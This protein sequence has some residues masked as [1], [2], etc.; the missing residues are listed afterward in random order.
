MA[1]KEGGRFGGGSEM[2]SRSG[3]SAL[4]NCRRTSV[5]ASKPVPYSG[6]TRRDG[7]TLFRQRN[8]HNQTRSASA[9]RF[10]SS[11]RSVLLQLA[12]KRPHPPPHHTNGHTIPPPQLAAPLPPP[13]HTTPL[14]PRNNPLL[15]PLRRQ[16]NAPPPLPHP[17]LHHQPR[18]PRPPHRHK[19]HPPW[20]RQEDPAASPA[21]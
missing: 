2:R 5:S 13:N 19:T 6:S 17:R 18:H 10:T 8:H 3:F 21:E 4:T 7:E 12:A 16:P 20:L 14:H 11:F 1:W 15:S 9:G